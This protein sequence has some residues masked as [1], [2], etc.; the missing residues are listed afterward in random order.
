MAADDVVFVQ[1]VAGVLAL[2][3]IVGVMVA[4]DAGDIQVGPA[5]QVGDA[6][7]QIDGGD[8]GAGFS[9]AFLEGRNVGGLALAPQPDVGGLIFAQ[10][11]AGEIDFVIFE[12]FVRAF[13]EIGNELGVFAFGHAAF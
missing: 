3:G 9:E 7:E 4:G 13:D 2:S 6:A 8:H 11:F 12:D 1:V 10:V 5:Q